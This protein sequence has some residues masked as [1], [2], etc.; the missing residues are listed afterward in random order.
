MG[1]RLGTRFPLLFEHTKATWRAELEGFLDKDLRR[2]A[3]GGHRLDGLES[4]WTATV[5][6]PLRGRERRLSLTG[7]PDRVTRD[8]DGRWLISDY[9]TSGKLEKW[10]LPEKYLRLLQVQLPFYAVLAERM[11]TPGAITSEALGLGPAFY[12][13]RGF[14]RADPVTLDPEVFSGEVREG[15]LE[16][17]AVVDALAADG[18]FPFN[19]DFTCQWCEF[20]NACRRHHYPTRER[21]E[22]HPS[23]EP[24]FAVQRKAKTKPL[25]PAEEAPA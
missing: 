14:V 2:L 20:R 17:L 21:V 25:I 8:R 4:P 23:F 6:V 16:S 7:V 22:H 5:T 1:R 13:D 12:P 15:F 10:I 19:N 18:L 3:A 11:R 9:K 24:Y